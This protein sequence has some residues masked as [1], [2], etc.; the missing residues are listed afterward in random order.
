[1]A[2]RRCYDSFLVQIL[3]RGVLVSNAFRTK[4]QLFEYFCWAEACLSCNDVHFNAHLFPFCFVFLKN[5]LFSSCKCCL[6]SLIPCSRETSLGDL[7]VM[8]SKLCSVSWLLVVICMYRAINF[9]P[10]A[11]KILR[12]GHLVH[13][14]FQNQP[15]KSKGQAGLHLWLGLHY[16]FCYTDKCSFQIDPTNTK[17]L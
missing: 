8:M 4:F 17:S 13:L 11:A 14:I 12:T 16:R 6:V 2:L 3:C 1:M 10:H 9:I 7:L 15:V 5:N